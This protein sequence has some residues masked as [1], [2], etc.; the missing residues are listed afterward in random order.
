MD[1]NEFKEAVI[2][3]VEKKLLDDESVVIRQ[4]TKNNQQTLDG[5]FIHNDRDEIRPTLYLQHLYETFGDEDGAEEAADIILKV[6]AGYSGIKL[7]SQDYVGDFEAARKRLAIKLVNT[8]MNREYLEDKPHR[9]FLDLSELC[10]ILVFSPDGDPGGIVVTNELLENWGVSGRMVLDM[11][12]ENTEKLM[13]TVFMPLKERIEDMVMD[14]E[15]L[16]GTPF[17]VDCPAIIITNNYKV[18]GAANMLNKELMEKCA[19]IFGGD[20]I[21]IPSSVHEI[22]LIDPALYPDGSEL[23]RSIRDVNLLDE[24]PN[25]LSDHYYVYSAEKHEITY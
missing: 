10:F 12:E 20:F 13:G 4:V 8:E 16:K 11:A 17:D 3:A 7:M 2:S 23:N 21:I 25:N 5:I 22:L 18:F 19:G 24:I 1:Y 6:N 9:E 14:I 15:D